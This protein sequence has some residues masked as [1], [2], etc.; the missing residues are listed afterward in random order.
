[1]K[2]QEIL[3]AKV[4]MCPEA[5]CG[6]PVSECACGP[7][8]KHCDCYTKNKMNEAAPSGAAMLAKVDM[9]L[10]NTGIKREGFKLVK[11]PRAQGSVRGSISQD[12]IDMLKATLAKAKAMGATDAP[13]PKPIMNPADMTDKD[14]NETTSAGGIASSMGGGNGFVGGGIGTVKRTKSKKKKTN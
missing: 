6:K 12:A 14:F 11:D 8:C 2:M 3:E 7:D 13:D 5:C 4:E 10:Q 1:M 9:L